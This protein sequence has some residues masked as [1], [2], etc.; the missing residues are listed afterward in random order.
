MF[1]IDRTHRDGLFADLMSGRDADGTGDAL[2]DRAT[3]EERP[4]PGVGRRLLI[5]ADADRVIPPPCSLHSGLVQDGL[6]LG[7]HEYVP[8]AAGM[9]DAH[10]REFS[11]S[12]WAACSGFIRRVAET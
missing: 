7:T 2:L 4:I 5:Q 8:M 6:R 12:E 3:A 9:G 10:N 11:A 1:A